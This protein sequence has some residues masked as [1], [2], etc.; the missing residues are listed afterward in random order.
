MSVFLRFIAGLAAILAFSSQAVAISESEIAKQAQTTLNALTKNDGP[1]AAFLIA[2]GNKVVYRAARG[3]A[4]IELGVPLLAGDSFRIA[5]V[6]KMFTAAMVLKL[7]EEG[8]LS[9][10]D[11]LAKHLSDIPNANAITIR[12]LLN[13]TAGVSDIVHDI[14]PGFSR[15]DVDTAT[16]VAEICKR[17]PDFTPGT[18]WAY[19]NAGFVLLG[20]VIEKVTGMPW[21]AAIQ[22][23]LLQPLGL[24]H[25]RFGAARPIIPRRVTGY[26]TDNQIHL[27]SN[28]SYVSS[29]IP[30]AAG[31]L[32]S[33]ENDLMHWM[34][35]LSHGEVISPADYSQMIAPTPKLPGSHTNYD[36]GL[37]VYLLHVRGN[38][39]IGHTGQIDGFTSAA[40]Y[41]PQQDI[42]VVVLANDD[43][44]D[45]QTAAR[46]LAAIALGRPYSQAKSVP[47]SSQDMQA[48]VGRF[49]T[50]DS[51]IRTLFIKDGK[52]YS[53][54]GKGNVI[55]LQMSSDGR[56]HF[57]PDEISYFVPV[58]DGSR[59]VTGLDYFENGDGPPIR[60]PRIL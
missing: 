40:F 36:Y 58:R 30:A 5:S 31:G 18:R 51:S 29:S 45:A 38:L 14:Q 39:M 37:G 54:R 8:K 32:V 50:D 42:T 21:Y 46:R 49:G 27:V 6:T 33:T 34:H 35:A 9:L 47:L 10:D 4:N 60:L 1:G 12:E 26:T 22:T 52:L 17:S 53:Q 13:H 25:T 28:V 24:K 41:L 20:A 2:K 57:M 48:L 3:R 56:L 15:R 23:R 59:Q 11:P 55:P 43:N 19:S 16:L 7:S 44:F